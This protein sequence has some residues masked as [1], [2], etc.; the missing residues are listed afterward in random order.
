M[1]IGLHGGFCKVFL[2][3][4]WRFNQFEGCLNFWLISQSKTLK[5][6]E[7]SS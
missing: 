4:E 1:M 3:H 6:N 2:D 7:K 5:K